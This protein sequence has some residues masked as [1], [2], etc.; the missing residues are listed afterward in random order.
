MDRASRD[1][2]SDLSS[3]FVYTKSEVVPASRQ[4][5]MPIVL[6]EYFCYIY[7]SPLN[8]IAVAGRMT[9]FAP[10]CSIA[11]PSFPVHFSTI[12]LH[13]LLEIQQVIHAS[14]FGRLDS[15]K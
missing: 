6:K 9:S 3:S 13:I 8:Y 5:A 7:A 11:A 10:N 15:I 4:T 12:K 14:V 2:I 1:S